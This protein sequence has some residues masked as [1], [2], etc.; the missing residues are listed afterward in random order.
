MSS[1]KFVNI[2][3]LS[4]QLNAGC[5][6]LII[7]NAGIKLSFP[8]STYI[9]EPNR[10]QSNHLTVDQTCTMFKTMFETVHYFLLKCATLENAQDP[11]N[12]T[13]KNTGVECSASD[14]MQITLSELIL[15]SDNI[16]IADD[17]KSN[18]TIFQDVCS[19]SYP[20]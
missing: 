6:G 17:T 14:N 18:S 3:Q 9:L 12:R 7:K 19:V 13:V 5:N 10:H 8:T 16:N 20:E 4:T 2:D 1:L 11:L 15:G